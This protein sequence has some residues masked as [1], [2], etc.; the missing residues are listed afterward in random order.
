MNETILVWIFT[1]SAY[2]ALIESSIFHFTGSD[3]THRSVRFCPGNAVMS[4]PLGIMIGAFL[5]S[6]NARIQ[7]VC[8]IQKVLSHSC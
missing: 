4:V 8:N 3:D 5:L 1:P 2:A 7:R 6:S